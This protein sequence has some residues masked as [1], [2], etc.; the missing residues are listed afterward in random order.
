[1]NRAPPRS[2]V[3]ETLRAVVRW[4]FSCLNGQRSQ[5]PFY[6]DPCRIGAFAVP[7]ALLAEGSDDAL[8]RLL[9]TLSMYQAQRD[10]VVM[11]RQFTAT[12]EAARCV[13]DMAFI[14]SAIRRH[15]CEALESADSF[16]SRCDVW[17]LK[18]RVSCHLHPRL[19]CHVKDGTAAFQRT[20][21]MGK[22]PS[23]AFLLLKNHGGFAPLVATIREQE[24][25]PTQRASL[26]VD[27]LSSI[28]RLGPKLA[29]LFVSVLST[30]ALAP[31][32][33]P[34]FPDVDGNEI[35][36][37]DTNVARAVDRLCEGRGPTTYSARQQWIREYS[38]DLDLRGVHPDL[39]RY[40]PRIV[41]EAL[42]TFCSR[43]NRVAARDSC[44]TRRHACA[45]CAPSIC[46]FT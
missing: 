33:T 9:I 23:S 21:D 5:R 35:V 17:K 7:P 42:Y 31:G 46:P 13:A 22:L 45:D 30:P 18:G 41:V 43:S 1:M 28:H 19:A 12:R 15:S 29:G 8:F 37:V 16:A 27:Q 3:L 2:R 26:L 44:A 24:P 38:R 39:P 14:R 10:V 25:S 36:V 40:S 20:G 6:C 11:R 4:H 34:W 32:L